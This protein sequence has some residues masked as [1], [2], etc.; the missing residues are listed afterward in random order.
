MNKTRI[1][2]WIAASLLATAS[3]QT[4]GNPYRISLAGLKG[5]KV[6]IEHLNSNISG[7]LSEEV[8]KTDVELRL[9]RAGIRLAEEAPNEMKVFDPYEPFLKKMETVIRESPSLSDEEKGQLSATL[10]GI[11]LNKP[12]ESV[13][14]L[15]V[16]I[17][18]LRGDGF[19]VYNVEVD[20]QQSAYLERDRY[21]FVP[22]AKTWEK[23]LLRFETGS[24]AAT[25]I[26]QTVQDLVDMFIND[27]LA[28]N[29]VGK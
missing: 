20:A 25:A 12:R 19:F 26:R 10:F 16:N 11:S 21:Q 17:N 13:A 4:Q 27:Y 28:M 24:N 5:V 3:A 1:T 2:A 18:V 9:R 29:S 22:G 14:T 8:V 7:L 15:D 23:G 6:L